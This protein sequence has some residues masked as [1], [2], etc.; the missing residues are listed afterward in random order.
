MIP[1]ILFF[2]PPKT[3]DPLNRL[4]PNFLP[5]FNFLSNVEIVEIVYRMFSVSNGTWHAIT[6]EPEQSKMNEI[7]AIS[8]NSRGG[9]PHSRVESLYSAPI[10]F[11]WILGSAEYQV[12]L[13]TKRNYDPLLSD[14][15]LLSRQ[16]VQ[17]CFIS[18]LLHRLYRSD[19]SGVYS[20]KDES[21]FV[22]GF[23]LLSWDILNSQKLFFFVQPS[24]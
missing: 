8:T 11:T 10:S 2:R 13:G 14:I 15:Y 12:I 19:L 16:S 6:G 9:S 1:T 24:L 18:V 21:V 7:L 4:L 3:A 20:I 22:R 5:T 17:C 23:P